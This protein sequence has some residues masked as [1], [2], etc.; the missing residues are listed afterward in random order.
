MSNHDFIPKEILEWR[1]K[2]KVRLEPLRSDSS[3][4]KFNSLNEVFEAL[5]KWVDDTEEFLKRK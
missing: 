5:N 3:R 1:E 2:N 4:R